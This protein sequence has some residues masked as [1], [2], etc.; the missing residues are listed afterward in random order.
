MDRK[1][2][3]EG[4]GGYFYLGSAELGKHMIRYIQTTNG[5]VWGG[6]PPSA[7]YPSHCSPRFFFQNCNL[8]TQIFFFSPFI[9]QVCSK[10]SDY[11]VINNKMLSTV[12]QIILNSFLILLPMTGSEMDQ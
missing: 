12:Q 2:V 7:G 1:N 6:E 3:H 10:I 11:T 8:R 4:R 9:S 5:P